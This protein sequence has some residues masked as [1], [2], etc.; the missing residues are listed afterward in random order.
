MHCFHK[1]IRNAALLVLAGASLPL[2]AAPLF[3]LTPPSGA[4]SGAPGATAGWGFTVTPDPTYWTSVVGTVLLDETNPALGIF[5]DLISP[6]GGP[7]FG[8]LAPGAADW[9]QSFDLLNGTG[10]GAYSIDPGAAPGDSNSGQFLLLY[11]LFSANPST[12]GSCFVESNTAT[13]GFTVTA[14]ATAVPEPTTLAMIGTALA[15][16]WFRRR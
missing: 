4:I 9:T 5:T 1:I 15:L 6:Q 12:C 2:H 11:E 16:V 13:L 3:S 10:F 14:T 7:T 8:V